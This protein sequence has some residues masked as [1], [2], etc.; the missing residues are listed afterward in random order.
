[1]PE[2]A[3][4]VNDEQQQVNDQT[5]A[6]ETQQGAESPFLQI[7][8]RTS[9]KT[10]DD[11]IAGWNEAQKTITSLSEFKKVFAEYGAKDADPAFVRSVLQEYITLRDAA[12][13]AKETPQTATPSADKEFEGMTPEQIAETK[14][15]RA[16]LEAEA[17]RLGFVGKDAVEELKKEL[18]ELK[19]ARTKDQEERASQTE[20]ECLEKLDGWL[21]EA[22]VVLSE[23]EKN[24][25]VQTI[26]A[27]ANGNE[28][29]IKQWQ[30]GGQSAID[31]VR[32]GTELFLP[33]VKPGAS[34]STKAANVAAQGKA[35]TELMNKNRVTP[36]ERS[37]GEPQKDQGKK[38]PAGLYDDDLLQ[39]AMA[40]AQ[41]H[42]QDESGA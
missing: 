25:L 35:K 7:N 28:N 30:R 22:K 8:D 12:K 15:G 1:M 4:Q 32:K 41:Q 17:K 18:N 38:K 36:K 34:L 21:N 31:L 23:D 42:M 19:G 9:Y 33:S 37:V 11:A 27:W 6:D 24:E 26:T 13:K 29:R 10:K 3:T 5:G 20:S 40:I 16:W 14:R 2:L 39:K